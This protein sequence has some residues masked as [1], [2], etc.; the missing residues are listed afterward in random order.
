MGTEILLA[1]GP[2]PKHILLF[3]VVAAV[4]TSFGLE[5]GGN[6]TQFVASAL[7]STSDTLRE[8]RNTTQ[9]LSAGSQVG[10]D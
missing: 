9:R 2:D 1:A 7:L 8:T 6:L 4:R 3:P 10:A 5:S